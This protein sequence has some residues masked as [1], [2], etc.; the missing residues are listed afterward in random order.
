MTDM[1]ASALLFYF[2][3]QS[4]GLG[5]VDGL[6]L[7]PADLSRVKVGDSA[8]DFQLRDETGTLHQL[9]RYRNRADVVLVFYRG[10]W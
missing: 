6:D 8:P 5:P 4:P 10:H 9:S 1:F 3:V 2:L 7:S